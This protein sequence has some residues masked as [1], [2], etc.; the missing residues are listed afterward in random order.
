MRG[1]AFLFCLPVF[2]EVFLPAPH[3]G[4]PPR[5]RG[6]SQ[7]RFTVTLARFVCAFGRGSARTLV[8]WPLTNVD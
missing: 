8:R 2:A 4:R 6:P 1:G 7:V 5:D 3:L